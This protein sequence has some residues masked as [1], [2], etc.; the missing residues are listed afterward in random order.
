MI[1]IPRELQGIP[2][3]QDQLRASIKGLEAEHVLKTERLEAYLEMREKEAAWVEALSEKNGVHFTAKFYV[4]AIQRHA[5]AEANLM[6]L[7]LRKLEAEIH[8]KK[9]MLDQ[10]EQKTIL[11]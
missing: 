1:P 3:H 5:A 6:M 11:T 4:S 7:E 10:A 9:A 8:I 2:I